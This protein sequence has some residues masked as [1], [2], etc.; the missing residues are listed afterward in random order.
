MIILT[1][2][3]IYFPDLSVNGPSKEGLPVYIK[4]GFV[5]TGDHLKAKI[6]IDA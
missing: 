6:N 3:N 1:K 2:L 5:E 4:N